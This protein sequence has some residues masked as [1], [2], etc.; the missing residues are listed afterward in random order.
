MLDPHSNEDPA[1]TSTRVLVTGASGFVGSHLTRRLALLG[2]E[3]HGA[4][5]HPPTRPDG[6]TW[7]VADLAEPNN[8]ME[9]IRAAQPDV[10]F[11]LAS[12]VTGARMVELVV[13]VMAA[14][15]GSVVNLLT[16]AARLTPHTRLVLAGSVEEPRGGRDETPPSPYAAAKWA[17]TAYARMFARLWD[18]RVTVLRLA[19]VYGPGQADLAKL[20]PYVTLALLRGEQP[21]LSSGTRLVDWVF[22]EDVVDA[23]IRAADSELAIGEV[24]DI[25]SGKQVTIRDTIELLATILGGDAQPR[26]GAIADRPMDLPQ[27]ADPIPAIDLLGWR[28]STTLAEGLERTVAWYADHM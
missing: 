13:P 23:F 16:A 17:A 18:L 3:V 2:A 5:R 4:S 14:N 9:L 11:H 6:L 25:G 15:L 8:C 1:W 28:T 24:L 26:F 10:V 22:V 19:M 12:E 21:E 7:H 27:V 20:V